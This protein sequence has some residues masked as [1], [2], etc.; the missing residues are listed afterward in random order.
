MAI[1]FEIFRADDHTFEPLALSVFRYQSEF[2]PVYSR[3]V[4]LLGI[5]RDRVECIEEIPFIPA[6]FFRR[7]RIVT[8]EGTV[9]AVFT[10]SGTTGAEPSCHHV[11]S[12]SLYEESLM[13]GFRLFYGEPSEYVIFALL[14]SYLERSGSS[15]IHMAGKLIDETGHPLSGFYL[16]QYEELLGNIVNARKSGRKII[17]LGI[18]WALLNLAEKYSPDLSDVIV[19]ET[20]GMKGMRREL[21]REELHGILCRAFGTRAVHSEYGMTEM[22]SQAY[23]E[24]EG[25]FQ[26]P[27]WM[28]VLAGDV[29]DPA[30]LAINPG[31]SGTLNVIDLANFWSCSFIATSDL[32]R[33]HSGGTFE[34]TGRYDNSDIRGCNLMLL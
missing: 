16:N 24:G 1:P 33:L 13:R 10:S 7:H 6:G 15:L 34:V 28:K 26:S 9:Q 30:D 29:N 31:A 11:T 5:D 12:V 22:L 25:L 21:V 8:G 23:S 4:D 32:C 18:T 17:L 27:P 20:G 3:F 19:M 14:P 2:N